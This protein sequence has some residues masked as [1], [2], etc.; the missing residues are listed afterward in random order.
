MSPTNEGGGTV[1]DDESRS[2]G[3]AGS[4]DYLVARFTFFFFFFLSLLSQ[5]KQGK[6]GEKKEVQKKGSESKATRK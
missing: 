3:P 4:D 6:K 5:N 1:A 2:R